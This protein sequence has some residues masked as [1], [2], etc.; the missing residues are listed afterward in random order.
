MAARSFIDTNVLI[1]A[2]A[3]DAPV[4]LRRDHRGHCADSGLRLLLSEDLNA[5]QTMAGVR[6]LNPFANSPL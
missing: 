4:K 3:N 5:G 1:Y 2:E 6:I